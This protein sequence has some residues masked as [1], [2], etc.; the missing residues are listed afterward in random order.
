VLVSK[1]GVEFGEVT[2]RKTLAELRA[3]PPAAE[4]L[5]ATAKPG[6]PRFSPVVDGWFFPKSPAEI[7]AAGDSF[8]G[9][10]CSPA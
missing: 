6:L 9:F 7:Y 3:L 4:L 10:H 1:S 5:E 8:T 2:G